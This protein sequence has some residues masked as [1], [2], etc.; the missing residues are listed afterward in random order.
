MEPQILFQHYGGDTNNGFPVIHTPVCHT[1]LG[2]PYLSKPGVVMV[3]RTQGDLTG[4]A[5]FL[6]GYA[7]FDTYL[8]DPVPLPQSAQVCKVAGQLCYMSFGEKR[9]TNA[10][11]EPYFANLKASGHGS[12]LE[13]ASFSLLLYGV[14]RSVT[15]ELVRH[16]AGVAI[17]QQ[18]QRYVS[19]KVL[20]FVE[21]PEYALSE[22]LHDLFLK[23]IDRAASE[24]EHLASSLLERQNDGVPILSAEARTDQRKKV[25][26]TAR[27][28]LPNETEAPILVTGNVRAWRHILE[29]RGSP[30]AE[31]EIREMAVRVF[32]CLCQA[33]PILFSDYVLE[34]LPDGTMS[35]STVFE[36]V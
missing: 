35:V 26:Q 31:T 5:G 17:S 15:H 36:K 2:T 3:A 8:D 21:R 30:H 22:A 14:S 9:T 13:H 16:R 29:M 24:Y 32:L 1:P 28:M 20:R 18:S 27:S 33:D 4:L 23:R 12:V 10:H 19:G 6:N 7:G 11:A 25:R 34:Q